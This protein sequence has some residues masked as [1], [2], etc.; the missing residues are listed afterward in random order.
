[1]VNE[2]DKLQKALEKA[3]E[4]KRMASE[5]DLPKI[6]QLGE[7]LG[8]EQRLRLQ[9]RA[10]VAI[11]NRITL[12]N[13]AEP[14]GRGPIGGNFFYF[15]KDATVVRLPAP[16]VPPPN[17]EVRVQRDKPTVADI[18]I[19]AHE[20]SADMME[21]L[22]VLK[23]GTVVIRMPEDGSAIEFFVEDGAGAIADDGLNYKC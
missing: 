10:K 7:D 17:F 22:Y 15:Y 5:K 16:N 21:G 20:V 18:A 11:S 4:E 12:G 14:H 8:K 19:A 2:A 9:S 23:D 1:M 13:R 3:I 6:R